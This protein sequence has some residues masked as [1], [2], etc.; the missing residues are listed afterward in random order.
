MILVTG[1][2]SSGKSQFA[3]Q[4]VQELIEENLGRVLYIA[5]SQAFDTEMA[6][7]IE[8]HK[9]SRPDYWYT[10]ETHRNI[11]E[12]I[13][14]K[15]LDYSVV[16]LECITTMLSNL[17]F[18]ETGDL[19]AEQID[20]IELEL[21]F[22]QQIDQLITACQHSECEVVIVTNELGLGIVPENRLA[23]HFREIA[24]K[25]NQ[26]LAQAADEVHFV[27]SGINMK[28]KG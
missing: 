4:L 20:F 21:M 22:N 25:I 23:R 9:Q 16:M 10:Y 15:G 6:T 3:E 17:L 24:G 1:G 26:R 14:H 7:R 8:K 5:T 27:V 28:I 2:A 19:P 13:A 12:F 18:D 11:G